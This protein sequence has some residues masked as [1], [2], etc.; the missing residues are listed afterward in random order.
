MFTLPGVSSEFRYGCQQSA[1]TPL[2][3]ADCSLLTQI[4]KQGLLPPIAVDFLEDGDVERLPKL[5]LRLERHRIILWV[6]IHTEHVNGRGEVLEDCPG[7][8]RFV[9]DEGSEGAIL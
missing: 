4:P 2:V 3:L 5:A 7:E 1:K 6:E 9:I 8:Q